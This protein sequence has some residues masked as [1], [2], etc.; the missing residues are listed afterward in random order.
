MGLITKFSL[1]VE[2]LTASKLER[3]AISGNTGALLLS[4]WPSIAYKPKALLNRLFIWNWR[5]Y[6]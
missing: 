4:K 5:W 3:V 6:P 1:S 2:I